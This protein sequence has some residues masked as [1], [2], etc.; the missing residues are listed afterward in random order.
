MCVK[1]SYEKRNNNDLEKRCWITDK[2]IVAYTTKQLPSLHKRADWNNSLLSKIS[3]YDKSLPSLSD[4]LRI[5]SDLTD[6]CQAYTANKE[7]Q[8][9]DS[10]DKRGGSNC[11]T[12]NSFYA[13]G[14][15]E[16]SS[17]KINIV[18]KEF[19]GVAAVDRAH[20]AVLEDWKREKVVF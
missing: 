7:T 12:F 14:E 18:P 1:E 16:S 19:T 20:R 2:K 3:R 10:S 5:Q 9:V 15:L 4:T 8:K 6:Q 13:K 17:F 11:S